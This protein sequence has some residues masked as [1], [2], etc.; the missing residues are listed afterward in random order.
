MEIFMAQIS[1]Q[2]WQLFDMFLHSATQ[3]SWEET[4]ISDFF[5]LNLNAGIQVGNN[6]K[7]RFQIKGLQNSVKSN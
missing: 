5:V 1:S 7:M 2:L 4:L 6:A 3:T